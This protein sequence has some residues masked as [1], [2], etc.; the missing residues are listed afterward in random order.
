MH[1]LS[2]LGVLVAMSCGPS[3]GAQPVLP[4]S[5]TMT[6]PSDPAL[7]AERLLDK[8]PVPNEAMDKVV[9]G[10]D[11][12]R[13]DF[14]WQAALILARAPSND[15]FR[16]FFCGGSLI[17]WRWVLTAAHCTFKDNPGGWRLGPLPQ[18]PEELNVYVG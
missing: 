13:G 18:R 5:S 8:E 11:A 12:K 6:P 1:R 15:P 14:P 3:V 17:D 2:V 10:E 4:Q 16:G 9:G 7:I